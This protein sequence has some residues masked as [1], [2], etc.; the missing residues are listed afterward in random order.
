MEASVLWHLYTWE[1][2]YINERIVSLL[3]VLVLKA[4]PPVSVSMFIT[5]VSIV[6]CLDDEQ[7]AQKRE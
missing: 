7:L 6:K 2:C 3:F 5:P 4:F 1:R